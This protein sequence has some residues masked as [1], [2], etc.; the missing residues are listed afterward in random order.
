MVDE[1]AYVPYGKETAFYLRTV[2]IINDDEDDYTCKR[3]LK[4]PVNDL[5]TVLVILFCIVMK[6]EFMVF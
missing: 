6:F 2:C 4:T 3:L 5:M 1:D